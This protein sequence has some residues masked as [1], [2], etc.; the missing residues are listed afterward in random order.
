VRL[1]AL[2]LGFGYILDT[3]SDAPEGVLSEGDVLDREDVSRR[4]NEDLSRIESVFRAGFKVPGP[5][6]HPAP[7]GTTC[8]RDRH[9]AVGQKP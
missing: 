2:I 6:D 7:A 1:S 4:I 5:K 3:F 8:E 9:P